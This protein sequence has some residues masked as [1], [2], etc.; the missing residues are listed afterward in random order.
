MIVAFDYE[1][2][3]RDKKR[4]ELE[5]QENLNWYV[6]EQY[7]KTGTIGD[8]TI[9]DVV[10]EGSEV[11][12]TE[13]QIA[14]QAEYNTYERGAKIR[15]I[16]VYIAD[17]FP[18][19]VWVISIADARAIDAGAA[20]GRCRHFQS[21]LG[22]GVHC[23]WRGELHGCGAVLNEWK[24]DSPYRHIRIAAAAVEQQDQ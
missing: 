20:C 24:T 22:D 2:Y 7:R 19:Y 16:T 14:D 11:I 13:D 5:E 9:I 15:P 3:L 21:P 23:H 8:K 18:G 12:A 4:K 17:R 10:P 6:E 1:T